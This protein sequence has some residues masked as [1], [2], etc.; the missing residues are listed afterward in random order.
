MSS[1]QVCCFPNCTIA[2]D[3]HHVT[4]VHHWKAL[5]PR[6]QSEVQWRLRGWK[7]IAAAR[8]FIGSWYHNSQKRSYTQ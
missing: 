7:D 3:R 8:A 4:C 1:E 5:P 6:V 2:V